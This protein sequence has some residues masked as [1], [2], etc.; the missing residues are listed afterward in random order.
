MANGYTNS[1]GATHV[2]HRPSRCRNSSLYA[3]CRTYASAQ[4]VTLSS[5]TAGASIS[6]TSDGQ[7][8]H[9]L[10]ALHRRNQCCIDG[11]IKAIAAATDR[12]TTPIASATYTI[13]V[14]TGSG[15]TVITN[16]N[17][18]T[19]SI[20]PDN[21]VKHY[22]TY[23][24]ADRLASVTV[25]PE[26]PLPMCMTMRGSGSARPSVIPAHH[27]QLCT[28]GSLIAENNSGMQTDYV[29]VDGMP[30]AVLQPGASPAANVGEL[31]CF[32]SSGYTPGGGQ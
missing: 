24:S 13:N 28:G 9:Q 20:P 6:Y 14:T 29:Y 12:Q 25:R 5:S 16:A 26:M 31:C 2:P 4:N 11:T 18:N 23:N 32:Q 15:I 27:L 7:L 8:N 19:T 3:I 1:A 22:F 21:G 10:D 30:I 17:G